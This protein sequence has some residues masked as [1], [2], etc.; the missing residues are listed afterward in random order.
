[1]DRILKAIVLFE[2]VAI[3]ACICFALF[4]S[5]LGMSTCEN[6]CKVIDHLGFNLE[7]AEEVPKGQT[8]EFAYKEFNDF[9][10]FLEM[11]KP[12]TVYYVEPEPKI[13]FW[14]SK[15]ASLYFVVDGVIYRWL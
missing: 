15:Q 2:V 10:M 6:E 1:M 12:T 4:S 8:V 5:F 3:S 11:K 7:V 9:L 14:A 13:P